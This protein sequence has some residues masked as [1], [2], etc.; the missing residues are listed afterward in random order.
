MFYVLCLMFR[1]LLGG[2]PISQRKLSVL[3]K[4]HED[5]LR[6]ERLIGMILQRW[7]NKNSSDISLALGIKDKILQTSIG[8]F[9]GHQIVGGTPIS[10]HLIAISSK[11]LV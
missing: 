11:L 6:K 10:P 4:S 1:F 7:K 3:R 2:V 9:S 8:R 5:I